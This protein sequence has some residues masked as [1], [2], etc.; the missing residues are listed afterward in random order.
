M[1][2]HQKYNFDHPDAFDFDLLYETLVRLRDGKSVNVPVYDFT[3]HSRDK[4][5]ILMYGADVLIFEGIL[6]FHRPDIAALMDMKVL[7]LGNFGAEIIFCNKL[8]AKKEKS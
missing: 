4:N 1:A 3:T 5:S 2:A 6:S 7:F 8:I